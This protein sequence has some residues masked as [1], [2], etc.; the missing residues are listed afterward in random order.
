M[1]LLSPWVLAA[2]VS[3]GLAQGFV[4]LTAW[5]R[6]WGSLTVGCSLLSGAPRLPV[7]TQLAACMLA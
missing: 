1:T 6:H 7:H 5:W 2:F 3:L 4:V